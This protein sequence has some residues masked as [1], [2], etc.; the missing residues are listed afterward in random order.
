MGIKQFI[1]AVAAAV[2]LAVAAPASAI[3]VGGIDFGPDGGPPIQQHLETSTFA[4]TLVN[5]VGQELRGYG[6]ISTVNG[7]STYCANNTN[8]CNLYYYFHGYIST[9]F[10]PSYVTFSGGSIDLYIDNNPPFNLT[11]QS[12]NANVSFITGLTPWVQFTGHNFLAAGPNTV[13]TL[14]GCIVVTQFG[15]KSLVSVVGQGRA[16]VALGGFGDAAV[17]SFLNG[18]S[19]ADGLGGFA[20]LTVTASSNN[21]VLN[22]HDDTS[23]CELGEGIAGSWCFQGTLNTRGKTSLTVP[24]PATLA[25]LGVGLLGLGFTQRKRWS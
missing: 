19:E 2:G 24:E 1:T 10:S 6:V 9:S 13:Q 11:S 18:N 7:D 21:S 3:I 12:S 17:Q 15:S 14:N 8:G 25:L 5:G 23:S 16:D 4:E 22:T 20:D